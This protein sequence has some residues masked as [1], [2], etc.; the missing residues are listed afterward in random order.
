MNDDS[1]KSV[2]ISPRQGFLPLGLF[3]N[4][5]IEEYNYPTLFFSH[6][7][8]HIS[9]SYQKIVELDLT[10][11]NKKFAYHFFNIFFKTIK[12]LIHF[13]LSSSWISI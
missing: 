1:D 9:C 12:K 6:L 8:P 13:I 3:R 7:R 10:N 4:T 2:T 5:Y 11:V